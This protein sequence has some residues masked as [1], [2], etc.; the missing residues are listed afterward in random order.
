[1]RMAHLA[2]RASAWKKRTKKDIIGPSRAG[3]ISADSYRTHSPTFQI[4]NHEGTKSN[5]PTLRHHH[6]NCRGSAGGHNAR[7]RD[8]RRVQQDATRGSE[9]SVQK[10]DQAC[11]EAESQLVVT[12]TDT[13]TEESSGN[14]K[15]QVPRYA[16]C[17]NC[18]K[19]FD[20]TTNMKEIC[21]YHPGMTA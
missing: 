10:N 18:E 16:F 7:S 5:Q 4:K 6:A 19:E 17:A 13:N 15:R 3:C 8:Q 9:I 1:M 11:K 21:R 20:V 14:N 2:I 12:D